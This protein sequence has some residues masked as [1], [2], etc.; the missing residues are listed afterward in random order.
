MLQRWIFEMHRSLVYWISAQYRANPP[1]TLATDAGFESF[2][3]GSPAN[4][5]RRAMHRMSRRWMKAFDK[6]SEDLAKYFVDRAAGATDV[7]LKDVLKK[8]GFSVEFRMTAEMN[9]AYQAV[10]GEN[11][12]LIKSIASDHLTQVETLVMQS[13]ARG[14]D[15]GTLTEELTK[16]Y[17]ITKR[18]A[19]LIARDQ[20][21]K[22]TAVLNSTR[23]QQLGITEGVWQHSHAGK[24]PRPSHVAANGKTFK[25]AKGMLIDDEWIMPGQKINC[26]CGWKAKIPGIEN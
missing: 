7:Q 5:M 25:L 26:R 2:R 3:D 1:P 19:S 14:R 17:D 13:V 6:G 8:A 20:A 16:R 23:Q 22:A 21:N 4:A 10:L 15:L 18:R 24:T 12:N 11:V 9:N